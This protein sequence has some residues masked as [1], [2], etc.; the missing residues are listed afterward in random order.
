MLTVCIIA[1][2]YHLKSIVDCQAI[3]PVELYN[4]KYNTLQFHQTVVYDN[5]LCMIIYYIA[6]KVYGVIGTYL[7]L[8]KYLYNL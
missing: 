8:Y 4:L 7:Y 1:N 2:H 6:L 3:F 5:I